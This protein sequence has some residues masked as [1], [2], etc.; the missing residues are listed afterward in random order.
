MSGASA[1]YVVY[2]QVDDWTAKCAQ[3]GDVEVEWP[4]L[5]AD[6]KTYDLVGS[7]KTASRAYLYYLGKGSVV[8]PTKDTF[9]GSGT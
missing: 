6:K 1:P 2:Y 4:D 8:A 5:D 9:L 3:T 7:N